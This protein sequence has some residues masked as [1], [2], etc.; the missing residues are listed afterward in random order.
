MLTIPERSSLINDLIKENE[1]VT[2][3][4]YLEVVR[5]VYGIKGL[6]TQ[7]MVRSCIWDRR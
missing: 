5:E 4:E 6:F 7:I 1:D 2:I 3:R